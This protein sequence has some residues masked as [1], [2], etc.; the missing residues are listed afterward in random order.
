MHPAYD[1]SQKKKKKK[2]LAP[3]PQSDLQV[4]GVLRGVLRISNVA[5]GSHSKD[6]SKTTQQIGQD[7]MQ[8]TFQ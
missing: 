4:Y 1:T 7:N 3:R 8:P 5:P 2:S 6:T